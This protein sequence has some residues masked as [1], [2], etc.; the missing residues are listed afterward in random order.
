MSDNPKRP[1]VF[2]SGE[3]VYLRPVEMFDLERYRR[4]LNDPAVRVP[5]GAFA[6]LTEKMERDFIES[7]GGKPDE[8]TF[9]IV[10]KDGDRHIGGTGL[11]EIRWKDRA[12]LF[13]V[14][15]G[16]EDCRGHGYGTE[17]ARLVLRYAFETLNLNRIELGVFAFNEAAVRAYEKAGFV[18][19][20]VKREW[21]FIDGQYTDHIIYGVL[22]RDYFERKAHGSQPTS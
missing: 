4:W 20:G 1:V 7:A 5:L 10:L 6:P 14:F 17:A 9:A 2:L 19:E 12:A 21:A 22:A 13:G 18:R 3:H 16:D 8:Y 11:N 15:I